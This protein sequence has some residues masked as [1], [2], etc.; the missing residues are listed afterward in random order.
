MRQKNFAKKN[1]RPLQLL[2][3]EL[4]GA[5]EQIEDVIHES[6][7]RRV[8]RECPYRVSAKFI[9]PQVNQKIRFRHHV[10][11][12][13]LLFYYVRFSCFIMSDSD[14]ISKTGHRIVVVRTLGVG[15]VAVRFRL[16]RKN[17]MNIKDRVY[18]DVE[19][20]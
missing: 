15:V 17:N 8:L 2:L 6:G 18:G 13:F 7:K 20:S 5:E 12:S 16:A 10:C 1:S 9:A 3:P 4:P 11:F 19:I 14:M